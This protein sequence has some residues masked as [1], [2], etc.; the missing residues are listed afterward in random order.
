MPRV[1]ILG[2]GVA[3][4]SAAHEFAERQYEV[5]VYEKRPIVGGKAR[6]MPNLGSPGPGPDPWPGE[7]GFRFFPGFYKHLDDTLTRI[8]RATGGSVLDNLVEAKK[9]GIAQVDKD[10]ADVPS[11]VPTSVSGWI[12]ALQDIFGNPALNIP[13]ADSDFFIMK[14]FCLLG[15][16]ETRWK[17]Q[18]EGKDWW[19]FVD[20]ANR[21]DAYKNVLARGLTRSLVAM[22]A[23]VASTYTIGRILIQMLTD[24]LDPARPSDRVLNGPTS[25]AWIEPWVDYLNKIGSN[26]NLTNVTFQTDARLMDVV[27]DASGTRIDHVEIS[28]QNGTPVQV[29]SADDYYVLALPV[30]VVQ[31]EVPDSVKLAAGIMPGANG[32][33]PDIDVL[34]TDWMNGVLFYMNR[35]VH[36]TNGHV[37]YVESPWALTSISQG[38]FWANY[39]WANHGTGKAVDIVSVDISDWDTPGTTITK[40]AKDCTRDEIVEEVWAQLVAHRTKWANGALQ[41]S[42]VEGDFLDP[43]IQFGFTGV[44]TDNE[45]PLL[46]NKVGTLQHRPAARTAIPNLVLAADYVATNTDLACMESA[47]EAARRA[48]NAVLDEEGSGAARCMVEPLDQPDVFWWFRHRDEID[49]AANPNEPPL[50]CR[51]AE[52]YLSIDSQGS[53]CLKTLV[54][55]FGATIVILVIILVVL[56]F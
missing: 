17:D 16:G 48:V 38:Q 4:L 7:H 44:V 34:E 12:H 2:G 43:A 15:S 14:L 20:A 46:I 1:H 29:G 6:S 37:V 10:L 40:R 23:E 56:L 41:S 47:N 51:V 33:A 31:N 52:T 55:L 30:E 27:L 45:E 5:I 28:Y 21:S 18:Y 42:D 8:P 54:W 53:G 25:E 26:A 22:K 24:I 36:E 9:I 35:D 11:T 32:G 3:G 39:P 50:L 49:F 13:K 19:T